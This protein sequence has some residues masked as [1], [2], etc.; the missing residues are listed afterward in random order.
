MI[1]EKDSK[2]DTAIAVPATKEKG[3]NNIPKTPHAKMNALV[4]HGVGKRAWE[5]VPKPRLQSA[6]D[7]IVEIEFTTICGT[8]TTILKG[9][10]PDVTDG[11][12]LGHEGVGRI[13]EIG[14]AV[15]DFA[16]G[17][18]VLIAC[19]TSCRKCEPCR[20]GRLSH[21]ENGGWI[22]GHL[23]DGTQAEFVRIPLADTSLYH[24]SDDADGEATV[25]LSDILP[26]G[27]EC[28]VLK[29]KVK[30]GDVVAIVGAGPI[31]LSALLT[32]HLY[33]PSEIIVVDHDMNRLESAKSLGATMI[34]QN[35]KVDA[36]DLIM[37][38]T[39]GKGVNVA[40]E[41]VG[42]SATFNI[43]QTVVAKGGYVANIGVHGKSVE[44]HLEKL[45]SHNISVTSKLV[46]TF[47][48]PMLMKMVNSNKLQPKKL[49]SHRFPL[50]D[51]M[52]AY[53]I[54]ENASK[55]K[56]IKVILTNK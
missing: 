42:L 14:S 9:D 39:K 26:T 22:L 50:K 6:T 54:F 47:T 10:V 1:R 16:V 2:N 45:W 20:D 4:F 28:G 35:D 56:A 13:T 32:A 30:P 19:V 36:V 34:I 51:I 37:K 24:I 11:R 18:R 15:T 5:S 3:S 48:I 31:G 23:I 17:D 12:V 43:C 41:A 38:H 49:I 8:D 21:C 7:A 53:D 52:Y 55:E 27:F 25:M 46:D 44:L 29:G 40:I 33:S